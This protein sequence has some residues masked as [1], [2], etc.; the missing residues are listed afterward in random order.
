MTTKENMD[1]GE[2]EDID[3]TIAKH[4]RKNPDI[5]IMGEEED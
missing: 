2:Y 1:L 4:I 5:D 3:E